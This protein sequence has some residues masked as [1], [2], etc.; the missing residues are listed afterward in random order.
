MATKKVKICF[1][2]FDPNLLNQKADKE[3]NSWWTS[4]TKCEVTDWHELQLGKGRLEQIGRKVSF[5]NNS[6]KKPHWGIL[7]EIEVKPAERVQCLDVIELKIR[8]LRLHWNPPNLRDAPRDEKEEANFIV[9]WAE[10]STLTNL[11]LT[12]INIKTTPYEHSWLIFSQR[13]DQLERPE[14]EGW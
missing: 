10:K 7:Q 4:R 14:D 9:F 12:V 13:D 1:R 6:W 5:Y 11:H 3:T 8:N 2:K